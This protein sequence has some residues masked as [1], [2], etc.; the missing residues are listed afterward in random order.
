LIHK[1][2]L[3]KKWNNK[4]NGL[5]SKTDKKS[6]GPFLKNDPRLKYEKQ[7][8]LKSIISLLEKIIYK[9]FAKIFV[10]EAYEILC[11]K[12]DFLTLLIS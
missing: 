10:V 12:N 5:G 1:I 4:N 6:T 8:F 2:P 3:K 7:P 9:Q 11:F